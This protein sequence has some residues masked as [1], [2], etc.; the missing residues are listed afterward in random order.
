LRSEKSA[1]LADVSL[2][3]LK[4]CVSYVL[5][6]LLELV[7]ASIREGIFLSTL[8]KQKTNQCIKKR[9]KDNGYNYHPIILVP[10]LS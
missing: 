1:G 3:L 6:P 4:K 7:N 8:K 9:M 5:V 2:Y 10:A